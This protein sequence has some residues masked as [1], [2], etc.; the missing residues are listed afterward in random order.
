MWAQC[1]G[2]A[3]QWPGLVK[4]KVPNYIFPKEHVWYCGQSLMPSSYP[5]TLKYFQHL[6]LNHKAISQSIFPQYSDHGVNFTSRT[7]TPKFIRTVYL[8]QSREDVLFIKTSTC[9]T[10][11]VFSGLYTWE[12]KLLFPHFISNDLD[13][14]RVGRVSNVLVKLPEVLT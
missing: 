6:S 1:N 4:T 11:L 7:S 8:Q 12:Q 5:L 13:F 10:T 3:T 2:S 14:T 9:Y